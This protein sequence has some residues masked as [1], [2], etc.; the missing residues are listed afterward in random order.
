ML[1]PNGQYVRPVLE[2]SGYTTFESYMGMKDH[3]DLLPA[4]EFLQENHDLLSGDE[5][6]SIKNYLNLHIVI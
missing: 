1:P 3:K 4:F 2:F 6:L 5:E